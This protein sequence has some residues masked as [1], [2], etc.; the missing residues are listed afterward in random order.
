M[1]ITKYLTAVLKR[2]G[3]KDEGERKEKNKENYISVFQSMSCK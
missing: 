2:G 1:T 3:E